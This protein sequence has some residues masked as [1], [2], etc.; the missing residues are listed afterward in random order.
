MSIFFVSAHGASIRQKP[1]IRNLIMIID[2][3]DVKINSASVKDFMSALCQKEAPILVRK[4]T[5]LLFLNKKDPDYDKQLIKKIRGIIIQN[6]DFD[7]YRNKEYKEKKSGKVR[8][9]SYFLFI[10]KTYRKEL[11]LEDP[12]LSEKERLGF[13]V[14]NPD[15]FVD[16]N[17]NSSMTMASEAIDMDELKE[18]FYSPYVGFWHIYLAG[19]GTAPRSKSAYAQIFAHR[20]YSD[21][22]SLSD[23]EVKIAGFSIE[24]FRELLVFLGTINTNF[25]YYTSCYAGGY[26]AMAPYIANLFEKQ[27]LSPEEAEKIWPQLSQEKRATSILRTKK[28]AMLIKPQ[29]TISVGSAFDTEVPAP[30]DAS[31]QCQSKDAIPE[32]YINFGKFFELLK[33]YMRDE[34][35]ISGSSLKKPIKFTDAELRTVIAKVT[36]PLAKSLRRDIQDPLNLASLPQVMFPNSGVFV[37]FP[38][39][40]K[41]I[42]VISNS[43]VQGAS[44]EKKPLVIPSA[45]TPA[46]LIMSVE[47]MPIEIKIATPKMP[48]IVSSLP[49][50]GVH[51]I[52][53]LDAAQVPY[54]SFM[55][56]FDFFNTVFQKYFFIKN[57]MVFNDGNYIKGAQGT[58]LLEDVLMVVFRGNV[59]MFFTYE[60]DAY[61]AA[62]FMGAYTFHSTIKLPDVGGRLVSSIQIASD[63]RIPDYL[64]VLESMEE[65]DFFDWNDAVPEEIKNITLQSPKDVAIKIFPAERDKIF[66]GP[67]EEICKEQ[68]AKQSRI[69]QK[70]EQRRKDLGEEKREKG[71]GAENFKVKKGKS[72]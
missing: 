64:G 16:F 19:H 43:K 45:P 9:G 68:Q 26:N 54:Y 10:P 36:E 12:K 72:R 8:E 46:A 55:L 60:K 70:V 32:G 38:L 59:R 24:Q 66:W 52:E 30:F 2:K 42:F 21:M 27:M 25:L 69:Q 18:L 37:I 7:I 35:L 63:V 40:P 22:V 6:R 56:A 67:F 33:Q 47:D 5:V 41:N 44:L 62:G 31:K 28:G 61:Y 20:K 17:R 34:L 4:D 29:F 65:V 39:D 1:L 14:D 48:A 3:Q 23:F 53:K 51:V 13:D 58:I 71:R 15:L 57:V 50:I 49:G 11:A